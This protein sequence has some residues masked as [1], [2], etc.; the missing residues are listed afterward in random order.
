MKIPFLGPTYPSRSTSISADRTIN[1]Y[2]EL[3]PQDAKDILALI[4]CPGTKLW[5][6]TGMLAVRGMHVFNGL[7]FVVSG[8]YL[9]SIDTAGNV[10]SILGTLVSSTGRVSMDDNGLA[11]AGIGGNQ[12]IVC[13]GNRT[14]IYNV[15][16]STFS[17]ITQ[18]ISMVAFID[19]YFVGSLT[20]TMSYVVSN[21]YDGTVWNALAT[22]PVEA[23]SDILMGLANHTQ[24]LW[25]IKQTTTEVWY[26]AGTPTSQ[27]SP[28]ARI[29]GAV[30]GYGTYAPWTLARGDSS[31]FWL[32]WQLNN[33]SS[34]LVGIV[35]LD[36]YTPTVISPPAINYQ[37]SQMADCTDAFGYCY[38][39]EGHTFYVITFPTGNATFVFDATTS[40]WHE[41]STYLTGSAYQ[42]N[43]HV[44]NC[45]A[46]FNHKH[47]VGDYRNGNIYELSSSRFDDAGLPLVRVRQSQHLFDKASSDNIFIQRLVLEAE[48]GMGNADCPN[49]QAWLSWS[50]DSG[51]TWSSEYPKTLG[52]I[53]E[54]KTRMAW[55]R[56][57]Y[58]KN[59]NFRLMVSDPVK[60]TLVTATAEISR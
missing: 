44:G 10:S 13:D 39:A 53:G 6:N 60:C 12:L 33:K 40:M 54:Y 27:G 37:I 4:D 48:T 7:M 23:S 35:K 50:S 43:R 9:Y 56:L 8:S 5:T 29:P 28:F 16:T 24:Q 1:W 51:K 34:E 55:K 26:D 22:S 58:G 19:G 25:L 47:Y 21:L 49:P 31:L 41:R 36:G 42:V 15:S 45:Y 46:C 2:P 32:G 17:T 11:S 59:K 57:G 18:A 38:S 14:Y 52:A 3:N 20:G 30:I